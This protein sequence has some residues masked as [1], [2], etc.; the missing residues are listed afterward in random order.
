MLAYLARRSLYM[1]VLLWMLTIVSFII[2]QLPAGDY[3]SSLASQLAQRG[4]D[5]SEELLFNLRRR[6]GLDQRCT[7]NT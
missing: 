7:R 5:V 6:Y 2:I 1:L 4:E 3:V